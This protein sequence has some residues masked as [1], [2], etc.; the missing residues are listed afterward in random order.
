M[1]APTIQRVLFAVD[2]H[3][4]SLLL[5]QMHDAS[6]C[7]VRDGEVEGQRWKLEQ[8]DEA[9]L[10]YERMRARLRGNAKNPPS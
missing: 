5:A 2:L 4:G 6:L 7:I 1:G 10:A 8:I 9:V 3:P